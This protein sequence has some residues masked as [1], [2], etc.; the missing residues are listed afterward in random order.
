MRDPIPSSL[1][2]TTENPGPSTTARP[3]HSSLLPESPST[4]TAFLH[5]E[6]SLFLDTPL[7]SSSREASSLQQLSEIT[8]N[9]GR[10]PFP[11]IPLSDNAMEVEAS[12]AER[13]KDIVMGSPPTVPQTTPQNPHTI[14]DTPSLESHSGP[15]QTPLVGDQSHSL[16][17]CENAG[18]PDR[19][20]DQQRRDGRSSNLG[21]PLASEG[22]VSGLGIRT[23]T[24]DAQPQSLTKTGGTAPPL[25]SY[26]DET[27]AESLES[28]A[29]AVD[30][31]APGHGTKEPVHQQVDQNLVF[32]EEHAAD[33]RNM[34]L[35]FEGQ[36]AT[37]AP[38]AGPAPANV[39]DPKRIVVHGPASVPP[40]APV[41]V[42]ATA[43]RN[44]PPTIASTSRR[45]KNGKRPKQYQPPVP[46][47]PNK[48]T[49]PVQNNSR[50]RYRKRNKRGKGQQESG[51]VNVG[52]AAERE[53]E[54]APAQPTESN[55]APSVDVPKPPPANATND[56]PTQDEDEQKDQ[57][58]EEH[59]KCV[60][61]M[62][63]PELVCL[64]YRFPP[65]F[66]LC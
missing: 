39:A 52:A 38:R 9:R 7:P 43:P 8:S 18:F 27:P 42:G 54:V 33:N 25:T 22:D 20:L 49:G 29:R 51:D 64:N 45:A 59:F 63:P 23:E 2:P 65:P 11:P 14:L 32:K 1:L 28:G 37:V 30:P 40:S 5:T 60:A 36:E 13:A 62:M 50:K 48:I 35:Y 21:R 6:P 41:R 55:I 61:K 56:V 17:P 57:V 53:P 15:L 34:P 31:P 44:Q 16:S 66:H 3:Q 4:D 26:A 24:F 46:G 12:G 58:I 10:P 19:G 47:P